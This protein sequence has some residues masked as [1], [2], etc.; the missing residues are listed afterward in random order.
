MTAHVEDGGVDALCEWHGRLRVVVCSL[1]RHVL[2]D[3]EMGFGLVWFGGKNV[4]G[5]CL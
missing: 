4:M 3:D 5:D 1:V 2:G